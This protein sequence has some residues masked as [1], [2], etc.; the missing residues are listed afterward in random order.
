MFTSSIINQTIEL[1]KDGGSRTGNRLYSLELILDNWLSGL[2][3]WSWTVEIKGHG[4]WPHAVG[5]SVL[6]L[7]VVSVSA[8]GVGLRLLKSWLEDLVDPELVWIHAGLSAV[9]EN[10]VDRVVLLEWLGAGVAAW[11]SLGSCREALGKQYG[12]RMEAAGKQ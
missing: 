10:V 12:G 1:N 8:W 6:V 5:W 3:L 2:V 9:V 4:D 7:G 11:G